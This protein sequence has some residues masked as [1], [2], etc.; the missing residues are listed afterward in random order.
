MIN[1]KMYTKTENGAVICSDTD[2]FAKYKLKR[3]QKQKENDIL[4]S[5]SSLH[6][7]LDRIE[8]ILKKTNTEL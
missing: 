5:L 8:Q 3:A 7:R 2:E 6:S 1:N 4:S